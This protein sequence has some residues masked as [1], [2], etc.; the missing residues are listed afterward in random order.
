MK[1]TLYYMPIARSLVP[2]VTLT[3]AGAEFEVRALDYSKRQHLSPEFSKLNPARK[4]PLLVIDGE[5]LSESVAIQLWIARQYPSAMLLPAEP[6][7]EFK[8]I[9]LISWCAFGMHPLIKRISGTSQ[10]CSLPG[11]E[12]SVRQIAQEQLIKN[13]KIAD[14]LLDGREFFFDHFTTA[15]A[16]FFWCLRRGAQL[17]LPLGR[18]P[19]CLAHFERMRQRPSVRK[20]LTYEKAVL[21]A[22]AQS[23]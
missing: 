21:A 18:F 3:E 12:D 7:K 22:F 13:Y 6:M 17:N 23:A 2:Y 14:K 11:A 9:S 8:A 5:P 15:D 1:L 10:V 19:H 16:H 20:L 4:V